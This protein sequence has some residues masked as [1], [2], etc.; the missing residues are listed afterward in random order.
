MSIKPPR[1]I[2]P[3]KIVI[4]GLNTP[5]PLRTNKFTKEFRSL[6]SLNNNHF[7]NTIS[8]KVFNATTRL[9]I[10]TSSR[11]NRFIVAI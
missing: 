2:P 11:L 4:S 10:L 1:I 6:R 8:E 3:Q 5:N 7:T 9:T